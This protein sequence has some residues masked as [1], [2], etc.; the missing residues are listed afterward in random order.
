MKLT[1]YL[2]PLWI[3]VFVYTIFSIGFGAKGIS[4]FTQLEAEKDRELANIEVLK[5]INGELKDTR[6]GLSLDKQNF[7]VYAREL[8]FAAPREHFVRIVGLGN[9]NKKMISPGEVVSPREPDYT[10]DRVLRILSFFAAFT[11]FIS[12][13]AYDFLRFLKDR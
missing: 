6:D 7:A 12:I 4:A 3:G 5:G 8:G 2:I 10:P 13:G 11:V 9:N 1:R